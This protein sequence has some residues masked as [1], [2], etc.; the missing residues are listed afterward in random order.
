MDRIQAM[1][2][3]VRVVESGSFA[4]AAETLAMPASSVTSLVKSLERHLQVRLLNRTTRSLSLTPEGEQYVAR[5]RE[6]LSLIED[7]ETSLNGSMDHPQGR[8]RVDMPG[9]IAHALIY[10]NLQ[11]FR[12]RYPGIYLMIGVNDRQIDLIQEG[13]DCV[14]RAGKLSDSTLVARPLG[15]LR[16]I[17]CAAPMYLQQNGPPHAPED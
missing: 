5:C 2:V 9:G 12:D 13:V 1:Q 17:T 7:A 4:R 14:I 11:D 8:L 15:A 3:F 16:W 6:I 10:P